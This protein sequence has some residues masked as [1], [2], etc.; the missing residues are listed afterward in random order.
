MEEVP[1]AFVPIIP[2]KRAVLGSKRF[3]DELV[4]ERTFTLQEF[5][6]RIGQNAE[7]KNAVATQK[8][9]TAY[10]EEW[11][12]VKAGYVPEEE[13]AEKSG[14]LST[15]M[16]KAKAKFDSAVG[17][18]LEPTPEDATFAKMEAYI[19]AVH[20]NVK[21]IQKETTILAKSAKDRGG[22]LEHI[23]AAMTTLGESFYPLSYSDSLSVMFKKLADE[24][25]EMAG[26][27]AKHNAVEETDLEDK[28]NLL[29]L[30]VMASKLALEQR[31]TL[32]WDYTRK[33]ANVR[34]QKIQMDRGNITE[35]ALEVLKKEALETWKSVE[36]VSK[37]VQRE[38]DV[39]RTIFDNKMRDVLET[40]VTKT[41]KHHQQ[42]LETWEGTVPM[43]AEGKAK[44]LVVKDESYAPPNLM[45][46][47][48]PPPE[49]DVEVVT[50]GTEDL[51]MGEEEV[52]QQVVSI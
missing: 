52:A 29:I 39:W 46:S 9:L 16:T 35:E 8:F 33:V 24:V 15:W 38:M 50:E 17:R 28:F 30:E 40:Y 48:P 22:A 3:S 12:K 44:P 51:K 10:D 31:K 13:T 2:H 7:L 41:V 11:T 42:L 26:L 43:I 6:T 36:T 37:R 45:P 27:W 25:S 21:L 4:E 49:P 14:T 20:T 18:E 47:A 1:G 34:K 19:L 32:L 5:M 23:G